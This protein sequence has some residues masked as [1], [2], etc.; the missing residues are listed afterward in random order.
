M[1]TPVRERAHAPCFEVGPRTLTDTRLEDEHKRSST[2]VP[3]SSAIGQG[4][5]THVVRLLSHLTVPNFCIFE[6]QFCCFAHTDF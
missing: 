3:G 1:R 4:A 5:Q 6:I 2:L